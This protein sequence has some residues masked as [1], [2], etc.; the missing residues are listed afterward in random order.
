MSDRFGIEADWNSK[1][2]F[3]PKVPLD[4]KFVHLKI[5][6]L[7]IN[8]P[9]SDRYGR[10]VTCLGSYKSH[11]GVTEYAF[12]VQWDDGGRLC[13]ANIHGKKFTAELV[14]SADRPEQRDIIN[15]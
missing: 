1:H 14:G 10:T 9:L 15:P 8:K 11:S 13:S 4:P 5:E 3:G 2:P 12:V 7:D 6:E